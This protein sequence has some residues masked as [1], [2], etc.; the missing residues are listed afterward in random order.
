MNT[1]V[2]EVFKT[3]VGNA[4]E[5]ARMTA[6]LRQRFPCNK[7]NFDLHDCDNIL[8][9]EGSNFSPHE[10]EALLQEQGFACTVLV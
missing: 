6:L 10:V 7:I 2:V 9:M 5:A 1:E 8:R 4:S 3:S